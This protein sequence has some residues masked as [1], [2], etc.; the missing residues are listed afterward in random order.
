MTFTVSLSAESGRTVT[1]SFST[2][3]QTATGGSC[4]TADFATRSGSVTFQPGQRTQTL[5]IT[6]CGDGDAEGDETFTVRLA[7]ASNATISDG[8]GVGTIANDD[9]ALSAADVVVAEGDAGSTAVTFNVDQTPGNGQGATVQY[10][11]KAGTASAGACG[12]AGADFA[13]ARGTLTFGPNAT[14][15]PVTVEVCGDRVREGDERFS[16][17]LSSASGASIA[18]GEAIAVIRDNEPVP[19][20]AITDTVGVVEPSSGSVNA[21]FTVTLS[22]PSQADVRVNWQTRDGTAQAAGLVCGTGD[23]LARSG[24]L[25]FSGGATRQTLSV[26]VCADRA[27]ETIESFLVVF[28]GASGANAPSRPGGTALIAPSGTAVKK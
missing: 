9:F 14:R 11:L 16:L 10:E 25:T 12:S 21:V 23:Y 5:D 18:D 20:A 13:P 19:S 8:T 7:G 15:Q 1:A 4:G 2:G 28:T 6:V 17:L 24:T 27:T 26:P 3:N 22:V